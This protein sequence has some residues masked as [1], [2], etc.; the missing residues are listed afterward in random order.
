MADNDLDLTKP[1]PR[2]AIPSPR[3]ELAAALPYVRDPKISAPPNFLMWPVQMSSWNNYIYGDCV[4]AE[5]AFAK[6]TA[7]PQ[8]FIPEA[9]VVAWASAN[10][11]LNGATLTAVMKT[12]Q[13]NGFPL[14]NNTYN[15]GPYNSVDWTNAA[16][17]QSAIYSHGPV[18]IG[19]GAEAFQTNG[20]GLVTPGASG[21]AM[22]NYP[23]NQP[24]DHNPSLCGYGTLAELVSLFQQHNV[25]VNVPNGMPTGLCYAMFTWNSIGIIDQQSMLNMTYEAWIRNP[26]TV[27]SQASGW[28]PWF[29]VSGGAAALGSPITVVARNPNH[30][31]LFVTGA[32]G[33]IYST[34]WDANGGWA[35]WF[36]VSGGAAALGSPITAVARN[37]NHLDL[38]VTGADGRIYSTWWDANG[39]WANWFNVSGGAAALRSRVEV[40]SRNPN[41]LDLFVTGTDG[42]IYST[43]WDANGGWANWFNV[44]GGAA[45]LGS[46]ITAVARNPNHLDLFVTGADGRI[47]STWWDANGGWANWFNVSGGTAALGSPITAVARNP[48]HLDLFVTG[49]DGRIYSTWWD[50]NGGWANWF[51]VSGG[52]AA[53]RSR[54]N[55]VA[56]NPNHLDLFVTGTDGR[57]D[58]T[59]WDANGGWANWFNV[60]GG[61]AALGAPIDVIARYPDHLDLFVT[62]TDG[63]I[64]STWWD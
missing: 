55:V 25:T 22:Y 17:L 44:S 1:L 43:W 49:A 42:R 59:W 5:E 30:L 60:S 32:D 38:F 21:W 23:K 41:H 6:A 39:G 12:M 8:T 18:K 61:A 9:T 2:G 16:I 24:E 53:L 31:D 58:S 7:A 14:N 10:G 20:N 62:G 64:Y 19:V 47:Y 36:N 40:V 56:R 33:R 35:N 52:A 46:P 4:S 13:T 54:I 48:N 34:W 3:H 51:N 57:V 37:P 29:R 50:A 45:A 63:G 11:Y 26:V 27:I 15:D 28:H